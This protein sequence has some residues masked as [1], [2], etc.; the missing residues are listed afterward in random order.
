MRRPCPP[1]LAF[2]VALFT[3]PSSALAREHIIQPQET[4][5]HIAI[6]YGCPVGSILAAN[7]ET[8]SAADK[9]WPGQVLRI[10]RCKGKASGKKQGAAAATACDWGATN[11]EAKTLRKKMRAAGFKAPEKFRAMVMETRLSRNKKHIRSHRLLSYGKLAWAHQGWNPASTVKL[12]SAI[13]ALEQLRRHGF[14]VGTT[15]TFHYKSGD[16]TFPL[17]QLFEEAVH[18][19]KNIPHNRLVQLA[20]FDDLNG[21][22]GTLQRAGLDHTYIMRAYA[23]KEWTAQGQDR[24]LRHSP[25]ITLREGRRTKRLPARKGKGRYPCM[26]AACTSLSDLAK[27]MCRMM[28]HEQLPAKR[29]FRLGRP[30]AGQSPHLRLLRQAMDAKREGRT[31]RVWDAFERAFPPAQGYKLFR[32]AGFSRDWLSENIYIYHPGQHTRW[33]VA[34][35]GYPGRG[36]LTSAA[37]VI[38]GLIKGGKL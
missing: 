16:R 27:T 32:K 10:P 37:K 15:V 35:A 9:I 13:G 6:R 20:G 17:T 14:G 25:A 22:G 1:A 11:F 38:A 5:G 23:V 18:L 26:G 8:L 31:D 7:R 24:R 3:L 2:A 12:F 28:L 33:I 34:M 29:R 36:S 19:S 30:G 4:L 21:P